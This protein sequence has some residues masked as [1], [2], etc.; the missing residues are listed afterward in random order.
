MQCLKWK[1][2]VTLHAVAPFSLCS[3]NMTRLMSIDGPEHKVVCGEEVVYYS[4]GLRHVP[5]SCVRT[6]ESQRFN[7]GF[8]CIDFSL[9]T[10]FPCLCH[11]PVYLGVLCDFPIFY[12]FSIKH[13]NKCILNIDKKN[14]IYFCRYCLDNYQSSVG[15]IISL[16]NNIFRTRFIL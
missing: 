3:T 7:V 1:K 5:S 15:E 9:V 8:L 14:V 10:T 6:W 12:I 11:N 4:V 13:L 16:E 2:S